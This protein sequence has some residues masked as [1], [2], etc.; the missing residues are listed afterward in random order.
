MQVVWLTF[1]ESRR[2]PETQKILKGHNTDKKTT[3]SGPD[4]SNCFSLLKM[5]QINQPDDMD[6]GV[7]IQAPPCDIDGGHKIPL[8][9]RAKDARWVSMNIHKWKSWGA[10]AGLTTPIPGTRRLLGFAESGELGSLIFFCF[11]ALTEHPV[12]QKL[13][14]TI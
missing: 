1:A 14:T 2:Q 4:L 12:A 13:I 5:Q 10:G 8:K 3:V 6:E 7:E 9:S 11:S